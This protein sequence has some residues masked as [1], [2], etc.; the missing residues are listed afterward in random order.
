VVTRILLATVALGAV[1]TPGQE[2]V[3]PA[4]LAMA[5]TERQF[6]AAARVSGVR[7]AFLEFFADEAIAF[8]PQPVKAQDQ[9]RRQQPQPFSV[10]ELVWEPRTGDVAASGELG[11]LTGP[12]TFINHGAQ[13]QSPRYG[14]YLSVWRKEPDGK[15]RVFIDV[16][17]HVKAPAAFA[18]G[19][20][21]FKVDRRY[22]GKQSEAAAGASLATADRALNARIATAG[23]A[24]A[25]SDAL[26]SGGRVHRDSVGPLTEAPA[27]RAWMEQHAAGLTAQTG[28]AVSAISGDLGYSY[29]TYEIGAGSKPGAYVRVWSRDAGGR[30]RVVADVLQPP[31]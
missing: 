22:A 9:L 26:A 29:G 3:P 16:G 10:R 18:P 5:D 7:N 30:W 20:T 13:D 21:R 31:R 14:N 6:A 24:A 2:A 8:E 15:W 19:F 1:L 23:A 27:V 17:T 12:S 4:L 28:A 11:W 25:Y